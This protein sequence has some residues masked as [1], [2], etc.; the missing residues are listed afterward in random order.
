MVQYIWCKT[1]TISN[2]LGGGIA[3]IVVVCNYYKDCIIEVNCDYVCVQLGGL[4]FRW[5]RCPIW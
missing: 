3:K 2:F 5:F 4:G 1:A